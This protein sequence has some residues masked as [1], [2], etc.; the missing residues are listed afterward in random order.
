VFDCNAAGLIVKMFLQFAEQR[1]QEL[2][3]QA[4]FPITK[5]KEIN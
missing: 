1:K 5:R 2:E 4:L 3:V